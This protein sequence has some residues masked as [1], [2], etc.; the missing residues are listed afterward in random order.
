[1]ILAKAIGTA[2]ATVKHPSMDGWKLLIVQPMLADGTTPDGDPLLAVDSTG[3]RRG[4]T[5]ILTSDG[6]GTRELLKSD[7]SPVRWM[8]MGIQD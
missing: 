7:T 3:A 5:V 2:T 8:V 6:R 4:D 1:M